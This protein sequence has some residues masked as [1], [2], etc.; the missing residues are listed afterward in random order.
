MMSSC[1]I[2]NLPEVFLLSREMKALLVTNKLMKENIVLVLVN[3]QSGKVGKYY[4]TKDEG[5]HLGL[6]DGNSVTLFDRNKER[7]E[8]NDRFLVI[9]LSHLMTEV[10]DSCYDNFLAIYKTN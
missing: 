4:I 5:K 3:L 1:E 6:H 7:K 8:L 10:C 2:H 9:K